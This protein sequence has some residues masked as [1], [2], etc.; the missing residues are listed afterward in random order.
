MRR[1]LWLLALAIVM[2]GAYV[3][4]PFLTIWRLGTA[5][6]QSDDLAIDA[7]IDWT[8]VKDGLKSQF[9]TASVLPEL[10]KTGSSAEAVGSALGLTLGSALVDRLLDGIAT[11]KTVVSIYKGIPE[12]A[13][14]NMDWIREVRFL[15]LSQFHFAIQNPDEKSNA[16]KVILTLEGAEWKVTR[17]LFPDPANALAN[18]NSQVPKSD[19]QNNGGSEIPA[20]GGDGYSKP[21]RDSLKKLIEKPAAR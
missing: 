16:I 6:R 5:A 19:V 21:A 8:K 4:Y 9:F 20:P 15:S 13:S 1:L 11:G 10:Q 17:V 18:L 7:M 14:I 2:A 12:A 3:C